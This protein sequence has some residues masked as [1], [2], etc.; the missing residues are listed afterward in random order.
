MSET[1]V[2]QHLRTSEQSAALASSTEAVILDA[3]RS[4]QYGSVEIIVHDSRVVQI[5]CRK[6]IRLESLGSQRKGPKES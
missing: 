4:L 5:E 3:V 1:L 2:H 6:K